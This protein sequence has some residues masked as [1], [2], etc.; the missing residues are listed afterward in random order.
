MIFQDEMICDFLVTSERKHL[1]AVFLDMLQEFD[2]LCKKADITYWVIFGACLGAVR[3]KGFIPWDDDVDIAVPRKDFDRLMSM[4]NEEFG[5]KEPY[6]LQN[7]V[8]DPNYIRVLARFRRSDTTSIREEDW[9]EIRLNNGAPYNMGLSLAIFPLDNYPKHSSL[10]K[11]QRW[12]YLFL[13]NIRDRAIQPANGE[14]P[15]RRFIA[16]SFVSVLGKRNFAMLRHAS[17][18]CFRKNRS[19]MVQV[20]QGTYPENTC[21]NASVFDGTATLPFED[22]KIPVPANYDEYLSTTYG[23]YME[24]PPLEKRQ[25]NHGGYESYNTPYTECVEKLLSGELLFPEKNG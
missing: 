16:H 6:F 13:Y 2:R 5:A 4:T 17:Y 21:Y 20:F 9:A 7:P 14:T 8:N 15:F 11:L 23:N 25:D 22:I 24:F 18:R 19:G 12:I 3:H 10:Q 1:N